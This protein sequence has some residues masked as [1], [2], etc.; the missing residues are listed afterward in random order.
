M[1][2]IIE[3]VRKHDNYEQLDIVLSDILGQLVFGT[4]ADKFEGGLDELSRALGFIGERP[5]KEWEEG[6]DN[7][8]A[9]DDTQYIL[10][11]CK[12]EV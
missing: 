8:W 11:E 1:E 12:N 4:K 9:L 3:W 2:R 10:W 5:D 7:L 6:P